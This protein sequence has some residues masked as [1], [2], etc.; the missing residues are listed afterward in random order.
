MG[1][2]SQIKFLPTFSFFAKVYVNLQLEQ[3]LKTLYLA[4]VFLGL[5]ACGSGVDQTTISSQ[6]SFS[7]KEVYPTAPVYRFAKS[8]GAYFYTG[9]AVEAETIR[10]SYPDFR[11]EG[12]AF[13]Q[14]TSGN[15]QRV[16]RFANLVTGGYF[17]TASVAEK[18]Y[19]LTDPVY[20]VRFR[21]DDA[22]FFVALDSDVAALPV[23]RAANRANGTYLYTLSQPEVNYAVNVIG[24]WNDEGLKFKVPNAPIP[25]AS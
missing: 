12:V 9:S 3:I 13:N 17:Y 7:E 5:V 19:V 2:V 21:L 1:N 15:G 6:N 25:N 10:L 4:L 16:Y 22:G 14:V 23:Y 20:K 8:N 24:T 18:D 11:Y